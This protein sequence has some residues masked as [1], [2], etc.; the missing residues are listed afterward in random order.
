MLSQIDGKDSN[1]EIT[2][3]LLF[4]WKR[5]LCKN[6]EYPAFDNPE[7]VMLPDMLT[8]KMSDFSG[9]ACYETT[10]ALDDLKTLTLEI[11]NAISSVEVFVN[12]ET[13]GIKAKPPYYY[14]LSN[15]TWQGENYLAIEVAIN[16][17]RKYMKVGEKQPCIMGNIRLLIKTDVS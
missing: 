10:F 13:L 9:F 15:F 17:D 8:D 11:S 16:I 3:I 4:N 12:G 7:Q 14:D 6:I 2:E 1:I 5:S